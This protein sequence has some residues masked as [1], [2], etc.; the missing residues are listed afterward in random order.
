MSAGYTVRVKSIQN[1]ANKG[2]NREW[3]YSKHYT[4]DRCGAEFDHVVWRFCIDCWEQCDLCKLYHPKED[5][6]PYKNEV[7][8]G[9]RFCVCCTRLLEEGEKIDSPLHAPPFLFM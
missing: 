4:C 6:K 2:L 9:E 8:E 3:T 5:V 7:M 1:D